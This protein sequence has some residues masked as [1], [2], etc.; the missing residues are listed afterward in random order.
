M[1]TANEICSEYARTAIRV[2]TTQ[3]IHRRGFKRSER[4]DI[5]QDLL[6]YLL[7]QADRFDPSRSSI[8]TFI[9]RVIDSGAAMLVRDRKR[10]KRCPEKGVEIKSLAQLVDQDDQPP[11]SLAS[12]I[13]P[14]DQ[15][16]RTGTR[17]VSKAEVFEL[18]ESL[19]AANATMSPRLQAVCRSL[20]ERNRTQ[21]ASE[22]NLSR[23]ELQAA[24]DVIRERYAEAGLKKSNLSAQT[25]PQ[26]A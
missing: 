3:L 1:C 10:L 24:I 2:K 23:R 20:M 18:V 26:T 17:S 11:T 5:E 21:T 9:A 12:L 13:S 22:L 8:N 6:V 16:R 19:A 4:P 14:E 15:E 25:A 7:S